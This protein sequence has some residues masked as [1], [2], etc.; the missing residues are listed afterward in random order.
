MSSLAE[1]ADEIL[2]A[3]PGPLRGKKR[4]LA[5]V[6]GCTAGLVSQWLNGQ[7]ISIGYELAKNIE[8]KLGYS[9]DWL[10]NGKG[11]KFVMAQ[12]KSISPSSCISDIPPMV[13]E[14]ASRLMLLPEEKL[15]ALS[16]LVGMKLK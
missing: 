7:T 5:A 8:R 1:R 15:H 12:S 11:Q 16:V 13:L 4:E 10:I 2:S 3:M 14:L 9:A 6:A